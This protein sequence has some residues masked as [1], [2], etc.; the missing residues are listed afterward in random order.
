M[1]APALPP[2]SSGSADCARHSIDHNGAKYET[3]L[4]PPSSNKDTPGC[5]RALN[6]MHAMLGTQV[7]RDLRKTQR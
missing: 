6:G 5:C 1:D 4:P 3:Q 7:M 2:A